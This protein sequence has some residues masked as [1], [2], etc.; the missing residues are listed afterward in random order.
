VKQVKIVWTANANRAKESKTL[1]RRRNESTTCS[2]QEDKVSGDG[3]GKP[4]T[5][6]EV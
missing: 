2:I 1:F 6:A 4:K 5:T 3:S